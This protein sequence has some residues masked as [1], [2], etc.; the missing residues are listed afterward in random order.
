MAAGNRKGLID[1][2][3]KQL[4]QYSDLIAEE[5]DLERRIAESQRKI[6]KYE[7]MVVSDTVSGSRGEYDI[8]GPIKIEGYAHRGYARAKRKEKEYKKQLEEARDK[9]R[10]QRTEIE[11]Y[12]QNIPNGIARRIA[13]YKCEDGLSWQQV[14]TK[15][16]KGYTA[17]GCRMT[18]KRYVKR[19]G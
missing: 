11:E 12:I 4:L 16:G 18:L 8:Y 7:N 14:A 3:I 2:D 9:I 6:E 1:M 10:A 5:K 15:M 17:D 13:R 19:I